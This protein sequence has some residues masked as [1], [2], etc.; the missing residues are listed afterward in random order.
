[1]EQLDIVRAFPGA[2]CELHEGGLFAIKKDGRH[3]K[4]IVLF[5]AFLVVRSDLFTVPAGAQILGQ[6]LGIDIDLT[7]NGQEFERVGNISF[8]DVIRPERGQ[9]EAVER[10]LAMRVED[11]LDGFM[12]WDITAG[13]AGILPGFPH[14]AAPA[15]DLLQ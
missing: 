9:M 2:F 14:V 4:N 3:A 6:N 12:R 15:V 5:V 1:M 10:F 8:V 7:G 13:E 11:T